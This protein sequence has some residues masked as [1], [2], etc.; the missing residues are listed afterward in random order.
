M[1]IKCDDNGIIFDIVTGSDW[2]AG[3]WFDWDD[4]VERWCDCPAADAARM[5]ET[6]AHEMW[7]QQRAQVQAQQ[8]AADLAAGFEPIPF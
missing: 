2:H 5:A 6:R 4:V 3:G 8:D 7:E 1:C